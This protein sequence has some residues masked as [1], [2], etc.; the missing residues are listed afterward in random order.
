VGEGQNEGKARKYSMTNIQ[1][2]RV[3]VCLRHAMM[4][5]VVDR[6]KNEENNRQRERESCN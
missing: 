6:S 2:E 1:T 5:R 3:V 4:C